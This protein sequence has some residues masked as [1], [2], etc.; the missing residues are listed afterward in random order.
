MIV[1]TTVSKSQLDELRDIIIDHLEESGETVGDFAKRA[2]VHRN[3]VQ[4]LKTGDYPSSP[5]LEKCIRLLE[6]CGK[7]WI[8]VD[9]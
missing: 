5:T 4:L 7:T 6:A 8:I 3:L 1:P 9:K 2:G